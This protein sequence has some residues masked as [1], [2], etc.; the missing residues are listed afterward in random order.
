MPLPTDLFDAPTTQ[1]RPEQAA[2]LANELFGMTGTAQ[3]LPGERD[4]NFHLHTSSGSDYVFKIHPLAEDPAVVD[5]QIGALQHL[6]KTAP[7]LSVPRVMLTKTGDSTGIVDLGSGP[8]LARLLSYVPGLPMQTFC[9]LSA[10]R[11]ESLGSQMAL[12]DRALTNYQHP[13]GNYVLLWDVQHAAAVRPM[14]P[15]IPDSDVRTLAAESLDRFET[16]ALPRLAGL[17]M[18]IIH[19]DCNTGNVLYDAN[20][21]ER[22][23]GFLDFGDMVRAPLICELAIAA[24]YHVVNDDDPLAST[25]SIV[26]GYHSVLPLLSNELDVLAD[27]ILA[28]TVLSLAI[29]CWRAN[30]KPEERESILAHYPNAAKRMQRAARVNRDQANREI[31]A[32]CGV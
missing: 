19:N 25:R 15:H 22:V 3:S 12:L 20:Q 24:A 8:Q 30:L 17:R 21:T 7:D 1:I 10:T 18:Q 31:R 29:G 9:P 23:A 27:L 16:F 26:G 28:R 32:A 14:L 5:M 2:E 11:L 6:A 13:A 4:Q